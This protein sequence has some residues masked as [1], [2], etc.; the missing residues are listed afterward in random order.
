MT[1]TTIRL[2]VASVAVLI[3]CLTAVAGA[4]GPP[5]A[6]EIPGI[7]GLG[8]PD[9]KAKFRLIVEGNQESEASIDGAI[10]YAECT[11][12]IDIETQESWT[13]GRGRGVTMVFERFGRVVL[14]RRQGHPIGDTTLALVGT[15]SRTVSGAYDEQ[16]PRPQ[17]RGP[18]PPLQTNCNT[19]FRVNSPLGL[20]FDGRNGQLLLDKTGSQG[21]DSAESQNPAYLCGS[22]PAHLEDSGWLLYTFPHLLK[23]K[24]GA[25]TNQEI[26]GT[27]RAIV[28]GNS[29]HAV[30]TYGT[31]FTSNN[32][33]H[34][35]VTVR[36]IRLGN[37]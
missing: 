12:E 20:Y 22:D 17:C 37:D 19:T 6:P 35:D 16:G 11:Y 1:G 9:D 28:L 3:I 2:A 23:T 36:F 30:S 10:Q 8:E 24:L 15:V 32:V 14:M 26:F 27:R 34:T 33:T 4:Q 13:F 7:P 21:P 18:F 31:T 29:R 5:G 25:M